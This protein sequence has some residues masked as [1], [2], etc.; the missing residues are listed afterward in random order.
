[1][2]RLYTYKKNYVTHKMII[3][4]YQLESGRTKHMRLHIS[5]GPIKF[6]NLIIKTRV[7]DSDGKQIYWQNIIFKNPLVNDVKKGLILSFQPPY[8]NMHLK[9]AVVYF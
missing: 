2:D 6:N 3:Y 7:R 1:M 8:L 4:S 9:P 5:V